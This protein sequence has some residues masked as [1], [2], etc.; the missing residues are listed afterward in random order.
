[1]PSTAATRRNCALQSSAMSSAPNPK[2]TRLVAIFCVTI[3]AFTSASAQKAS[4]K[5]ATVTAEQ[6]TANYLDSIR[7]DP[8][9][10]REFLLKFPKGGDLHNHL[11]GAIY[12]ESY[13]QWA[14]DSGF[15]VNTQTFSFVPAKSSAHGDSSTQPNDATCQNEDA[16]LQRPAADALRDPVFY[17]DLIDALSLRNHSSAVKPDE[18]QF[19]DTFPKFGLVSG[20]RT[21]EMLAEVA[22]R[23]ALENEHYLELTLSVDAGVAFPVADKTPWMGDDHL[24]EYRDRLLQSGLR[25]AVAKGRARLDAAE[26]TMKTIL[27]CGTAKPDVGCTVTIRYIGEVL[28][29]MSRERVFAQTLANFEIAQADARVLAVNLVQ[30]EDWLVPVRDYDLHMRILDYLHRE[31]PK[32]HITLHAGELAFGQVMPNVLGTHIPKAIDMGHAERIGHGVDVMY[33]PEAQDLLREMVQKH[34]AVEIALTSNEFILG[35][36]AAEHPFMQYMKAGVPLV[37]ATD[38][39]GVSRSDVTHEYQRAVESYNLSYAQLKQLSFNSLEYGFL[40]GKHLWTHMA[41]CDAA[42]ATQSND[43]NQLLNNNE[44]AREQ[45]R[46]EKEFLEFER[47]HSGAH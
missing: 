39:E 25:D 17:R 5:R 40:P 36:R 31:Y 20:S 11:S 13:I 44:K 3:L 28:R 8:L 32:V 30:P 23:A 38:D 26:S 10:L 35:V 43:C 22:H 4:P 47:A 14:A 12:A 15:C 46:L 29:A 21:G 7:K 27:G 45:F 2:I 9:L 6:A 34:I 42:K 16:K 41:I 19:F 18:Y 24:A 1:M 37:I 33:Y